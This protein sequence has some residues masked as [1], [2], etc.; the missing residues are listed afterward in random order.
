MS[1][2]ENSKDPLNKAIKKK[3]KSKIK[4]M[5]EEFSERYKEETK[6]SLLTEKEQKVEEKMEEEEKIKRIFNKRSMQ[7]VNNFNRISRIPTLPEEP[8]EDATIEE[9]ESYYLTCLQMGL[10]P[11]RPRFVNPKIPESFHV[12][13]L[14]Y[15]V[16]EYTGE[17]FCVYIIGTIMNS[18]FIEKAIRYSEFKELHKKINKFLKNKDVKFPEPSSFLGK[19]NLKESFLCNRVEELNGYLCEVVKNP[20]IRKNPYFLQFLGV[21]KDESDSISDFQIFEETYKK[22]KNFIHFN[23]EALYNTPLEGIEQLILFKIKKDFPGLKTKND[24]EINKYIH[25]KIN[26]NNDIWKKGYMESLQIKTDMSGKVDE[27]VIMLKNKMEEIIF[28]L[29]SP[30]TKETMNDILSILDSY[31]P[32]VLQCIIPSLSPLMTCFI[33][34]VEPEILKAFEEKSLQN[35]RI[36]VDVFKKKIKEAISNI[37]F[38]VHTEIINMKEGFKIM[39][40]F[41]FLKEISEPLEYIEHVLTYFIK[42]LDPDPWMKVIEETL[43]LKEVNFFDLSLKEFISVL[44]KKE[45][46]ICMIAESEGAE[47][48]WRNSEAR[49]EIYSNDINYNNLAEIVFKFGEK[50][51]KCVYQKTIIYFIK[52]YTNYIW[53]SFEIKD[54]IGENGDEPSESPLEKAY[55]LTKKK[56]LKHS[57]NLLVEYL[58]ASTTAIA[59]KEFEYQVNKSIDKS[60]ERL[61]EKIPKLLDKF[62]RISDVV[63]K[64]IR[65]IFFSSL[66]KYY[67]KELFKEEEEEDEETEMNM[68]MI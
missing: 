43:E 47:L 55:F 65:K 25:S 59:E 42:L 14:R 1:F 19:R 31:L 33:E 41:N 39:T 2:F 32:Q 62:F 57:K 16:V 44:D 5:L 8:P 60:C 53:A 48:T 3:V 68:S 40:S 49:N 37:S 20:E 56:F 64:E 9:K 27:G 46:E 21:P 26:D 13:V 7:L 61:S 18:I 50:Y 12:K 35:L 63:S 54:S 67:K 10:S 23:E 15:K 30:L 11:V 22:F 29:I 66:E 45:K 58:V 17:K 38:K 51:K 34:E 4:E 52:K 6:I 36:K 24:E 28:Q